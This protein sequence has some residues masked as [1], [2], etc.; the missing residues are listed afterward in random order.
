[1]LEPFSNVALRP[2]LELAFLVFL[3]TISAVEIRILRMAAEDYK[4]SIR[5]L[6]PVEFPETVKLSAIYP[7]SQKLMMGIFMFCLVLVLWDTRNDNQM[8]LPMA[9]GVAMNL[10]WVWRFATRWL[11]LNRPANR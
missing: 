9:I 4:N 3:L 7:L 8:I 2:F 1:M 5:P 11:R 10:W 6:R